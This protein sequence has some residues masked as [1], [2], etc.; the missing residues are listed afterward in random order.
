MRDFWILEECNTVGGEKMVRYTICLAEAD[1]ERMMTESEFTF[2]DIYHLT[3]AT[4]E[5]VAKWFNEGVAIPKE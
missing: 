1:A 4:H 5:D 2:A 3:N